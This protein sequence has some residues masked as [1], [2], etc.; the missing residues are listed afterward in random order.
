M[1][2]LNVVRCKPYFIACASKSLQVFYS[3]CVLLLSNACL[4]G[5]LAAT[6]DLTGSLYTALCAMVATAMTMTTTAMTTAAMTTTPTAMTTTHTTHTK[7]D[8]CNGVAEAAQALW[9]GDEQDKASGGR[10]GGLAP[11][12]VGVGPRSVWAGC[13][14]GGQFFLYD[15]FRAAAHVSPQDLTQVLDVFGTVDILLKSDGAIGLLGLEG[16]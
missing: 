15:V 7:D 14:I 2:W 3:V 12:F 6:I 1:S 13:V 11:F 5:F 10:G 9:R 8:R 16:V 4:L